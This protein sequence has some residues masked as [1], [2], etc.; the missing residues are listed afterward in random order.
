MS[1]PSMPMA[2]SPRT[3]FCAGRDLKAGAYYRPISSGAGEV[4]DGE[5]F[6]LATNVSDK[7]GNRQLVDTSSGEVTFATPGSIWSL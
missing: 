7:R 5:R 4:I 3:V 2:V 1:G 6:L